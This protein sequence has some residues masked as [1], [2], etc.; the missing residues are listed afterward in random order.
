MSAFEFRL[1]AVLAVLALSAGV[2]SAPAQSL[3][4]PPG[5][6]GLTIVA[7]EDLMLANNRTIRAA[8]RAVDVASAEIARVDVLPNPNVTAQVSNTTANRYNYGD[9]DRLFRVE[10]LIER[11]GKRALRR[12][13][14]ESAEQAARLDL[15]DAVRQQRSALAAAYYD[16]A[17]L[18][19]LSDLARE[20]L[21]GYRRLLEA[22]DKRVAAGDLASVDAARLRIEATRAANDL[23]S[24]QSNQVQGQIALATVLGLEASAASLRALDGLSAREEIDRATADA[25]RAIDRDLGPAIE[26]RADVLAAQARVAALEKAR[27]LAGSLRTRDWTLGVQTERA[28]GFGGSVFGVSASIPLFVFNDYGGDIARAQAELAAAR[29][30]VERVRAAARAEIERSNVLLQSAADRARRLLG[31]ALPDARSVAESIEFAFNAGAVTLTDLFDTRRQ[32][33][34]LRADAVLAQSEFD[35]ALRAFRAA[36]R[37]EP[38][39]AASGG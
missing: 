14:A 39:A 23:R 15:A 20:N 21:D 8:Q 38:V 18:Q 17:A 3:R 31:S 9:T 19:R 22:A 27:D 1:P 5:D 25:A 13:G 32:L 7:A 11:G 16:L 30:E 28:P 10:Q 33:A 24:A 4:A 37:Q 29:E 2:V 36:L 26:R 6:G 35:K 12:M 34:A